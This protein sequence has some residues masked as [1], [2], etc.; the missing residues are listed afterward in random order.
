MSVV[1]AS[2]APL[3]HRLYATAV[4]SEGADQLITVAGPSVTMTVMSVAG[5]VVAGMEGSGSGS[6]SVGAVVLGGM[7]FV[8]G[9]AVVATCVVV[10]SVAGVSFVN[11]SV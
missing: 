9:G 7:A 3:R 11:F 4:P 2:K 1:V 5:L 6:S 10:K 8:F